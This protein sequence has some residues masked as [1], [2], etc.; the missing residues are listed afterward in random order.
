MGLL[1]Y[2][3]DYFRIWVRLNGG[4]VNVYYCDMICYILIVFINKINRE[5][6]RDVYFIEEILKIFLKLEYYICILVMEC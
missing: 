4:R 1:I 6:E 2:N 3:L 5:F